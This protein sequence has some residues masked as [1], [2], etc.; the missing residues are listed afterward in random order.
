[1]PGT[2]QQLRNQIKTAAMDKTKD[3]YSERFDLYEYETD[4]DW[5]DA[6]IDYGIIDR[7]KRE[8]LLKYIHRVNKRGEFYKPTDIRI[9]DSEIYIP[10]T[11]QSLHGYIVSARKLPIFLK[12]SFAVNLSYPLSPGI[13]KTGDIFQKNVP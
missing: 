8:D 2:H 13:I 1:M 12:S 3:N 11:M 6:A 5:M 10:R 4:D 7:E 9:T